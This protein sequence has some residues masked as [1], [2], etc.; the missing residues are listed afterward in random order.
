M[1]IYQNLK[2]K[3]IHEDLLDGFIRNQTTYRVKYLEDGVLK[4]KE[5]QFTENWNQSRLREISNGMKNI[6]LKGG[7]LIVAKKKGKVIGFACLENEM[8]NDGYLNLDIIQV[9][10]PYRRQGIGKQLFLLIEKE[11]KKLKA[12]KLYISGHPN[13]HTQA[14]Y[15]K[16][17]CVLAKQI[18][19]ELYENEPLD[20]HLEKELK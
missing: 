14:F 6:V 4:E 3:K 1:I 11:A 20:I 8:F 17:G 16:M 10:K 2:P 19:Q 12:K 9:S 15:K 7:K 13:I 5:D 18:N